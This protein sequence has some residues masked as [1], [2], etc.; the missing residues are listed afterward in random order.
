MTPKVKTA[1]GGAV[2]ALGLLFGLWVDTPETEYKVIHDTDTD[3]VTKTIEIPGLASPECK[4]VVRLA[5][6]YAKAAGQFDTTTSDM[7]D[8]ISDLRIA[9]AAQNYNNATALENRL[10]KLSG[11]TTGAAEILGENSETFD[12]A[13]A[14]CLEGVR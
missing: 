12:E 13:A 10:R 11:K 14:A 2:F 4:E 3:T 8:I 9:L 6:Q 7:L 5:R 1:L